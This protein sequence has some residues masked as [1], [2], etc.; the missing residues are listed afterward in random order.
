MKL[1][2]DVNLLLDIALKREGFQ[3]SKKIIDQC[4]DSIHHGVI[5]WHSLS[6]FHYICT[7]KKGEKPTRQAINSLLEYIEVSPTDTNSAK[8]ATKSQMKDFEDALQ[9]MAALKSNCDYIV[10]K[11]I[12]DFKNSPVPAI[13]P[14]DVN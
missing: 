3:V 5:A 13:L 10:T 12:K 2:L 6:I 8:Q 7:K 4:Q 9:A 1:L 11:N 14:V